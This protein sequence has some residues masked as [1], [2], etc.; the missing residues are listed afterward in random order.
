M[1]DLASF[2]RDKLGHEPKDIS[3]FELA[4]THSSISGPS[5]ER[6]EFLG[7]RVLGMVIARALYERYAGQHSTSHSAARHEALPCRPQPQAGAGADYAGHGPPM[8]GRQEDLI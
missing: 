3:L 6:L 8:D 1:S 2:V 4:I 5:Y 7:D